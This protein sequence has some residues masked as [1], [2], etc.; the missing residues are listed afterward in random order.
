MTDTATPGG[1]T[2]EQ[3]LSVIPLSLDDYA[4]DDSWQVDAVNT[5][6]RLFMAGG[7]LPKYDFD[8][9]Y[10]FSQASYQTEGVYKDAWDTI[11]A[12]ESKYFPHKATLPTATYTAKSRVTYNPFTGLHTQPVDESTQ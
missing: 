4:E 9:I 12:F 6:I 2:Y 11:Y 5:L 1:K 10:A 7:S 3:V 8:T